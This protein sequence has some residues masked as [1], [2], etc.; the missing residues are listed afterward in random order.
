MYEHLN[1]KIILGVDIGGSHISAALI[2][3]NTGDLI[4][5]SIRKKM[6]DA[7]ASS[8]QIIDEWVEALNDSLN[9][10]NDYHLLG[11]GIAMPGPFNYEKGI[12]LMKDVNKYS[13]LF[14]MDIKKALKQQL[15]LSDSCPIVFENDGACFGIGE[16]L[17]NDIIDK[18]RVIAIT[19]GT[20]I[21]ST[22]LN[23]GR[24]IKNDEGVPFN[25]ELYNQPYKG[26]IIEDYVSSKWLLSAYNSLAGGAKSVKDIAMKATKESDEIAIKVFQE[27]GFHLAESLKPWINSFKPDCIVLGGSIVKSSHLFMPEFKS[28][29][30]QSGQQVSIKISGQLEESTILGAASLVLSKVKKSNM[31]RKTNQ[32]L[33][34]ISKSNSELSSGEYDLYPS[35]SLGEHKIFK[36]YNTLA[37]WMVGKKAVMIDGLVG[38]DWDTIQERLSEEFK[39]IG[40]NVRWDKAETFQHTPATIKKLTEPFIGNIGDV[41]G[42][43][44]TLDLADFFNKDLTSFNPVAGEQLHILIGT[45]AS[46]AGWDNLVYFDLPKNEIQFRMRAGQSVSLIPNEGLANPEIYKHLYFVDW[47]INR[48]HRVAI[49]KKIDIIADSQWQNDITWAH[50]ASIYDGFG[51]MTKSV[52]RA[53]PWFEPGAWGGQ[54]LKNQ[55]NGLNKNEVNYAWSFELIV[56][57]NGLVFESDN[58]HLEVAFDWLMDNQ[59]NAILGEDVKVFGSE[60]PIRFDFLDTMDGGNLSIQCHPSL[61][62]I[63]NEFGEKITQDETYYILDCKEN[64]QVFLGFQDSIDPEEF[65]NVLHESTEKKIPV[66][67]T[68]YVQAHNAQKHDLFLIPNQTIHSAGKDNLVLEI[69]ATPYIFTFKMYDWLRLDLEGNP[70]PINIEHAF[71][72]LDF[73]RKG[74]VVKNELISKPQTLTQTNEYRIVHLPTHKEHFYDVHRIEFSNSISLNTDGKCFIMMLVEGQ[75]ITVEID[76]KAPVRYNYAETFIIPASVGEFTISNLTNDEIKIVKAFLK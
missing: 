75:A 39:V 46:L 61:D 1:K 5:G 21:G 48:K 68:D 66:A 59:A 45:G 7:Q 15:Q 62:Y 72:N 40:I 12:S 35:F 34:P 17:S 53:R 22:F 20:G 64:A 42:T 57:E 76:G 33:L 56:P 52:I 23:T 29:V 60:F 41:W 13:S 51:E 27:F 58:N 71:R 47:V 54:W 70:R 67:I 30:N 28:Q 37:N 49:Q 6:V 74:D 38:T 24:V 25:G 11:M 14:G 32:P 31:S 50:A 16:S 26:G 63:K 8:S 19:L 18:S 3:N 10:V 55:V 9:S 2:D 65:E 44:C 43:Q 69:S 4:S 73:S 36:G